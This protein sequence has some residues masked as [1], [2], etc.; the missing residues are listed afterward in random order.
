MVFTNNDKQLIFVEE[1]H[2][3]PDRVVLRMSVAAGYAL[4]NGFSL[5]V[6]LKGGHY[7]VYVDDGM[8]AKAL[9]HSR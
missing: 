2:G 5:P 4:V 7:R 3:V 1:R 9:A 8:S 6:L